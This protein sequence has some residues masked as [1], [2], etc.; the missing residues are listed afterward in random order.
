[1]EKLGTCCGEKLFK[2][3]ISNIL[4]HIQFPCPRLLDR[5]SSI[6]PDEKYLSILL[7]AILI[8]ATYYIAPPPFGFR[9]TAIVW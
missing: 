4:H 2:P 7:I 6:Y 1:M 8:D 9:T 3:E 5:N